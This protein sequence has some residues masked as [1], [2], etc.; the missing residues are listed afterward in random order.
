[1]GIGLTCT[2]YD[3]PQG[4]GFGWG[5]GGVL[6]HGPFGAR[7]ESKSEVA[8]SPENAEL[9]VA[10]GAVVGTLICL[11]NAGVA[12]RRRAAARAAAV[13]F[14]D[15]RMEKAPREPES[16]LAAAVSAV[17]IGVRVERVDPGRV[18]FR[19]PRDT[20]LLP[21][22]RGLVG[23]LDVRV[24]G[25]GARV[26]G[27]TDNRGVRRSAVIALAIA[28]GVGL[29]VVALITLLLVRFVVGSADPGVRWQVLQV[30]Q[31]V[32]VLWPPWLLLWV[33][34]RYQRVV[35]GLLAQAVDRV[36]FRAE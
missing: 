23:R 3:A 18:E 31:V 34:G 14:V 25:G 4:C 21:F 17:P 20:G 28:L 32:H 33:G 29:P 11:F 24:E 22:V 7:A 5:R 19:I 13:V 35:E 10:V 8:M 36:R 9:I 26:L 30:L 16:A 15:V 2:W 6:R 1:M 27:F 12:W